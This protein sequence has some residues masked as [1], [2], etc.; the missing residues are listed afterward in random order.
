MLKEACPKTTSMSV[1]SKLQGKFFYSSNSRPAHPD[2][3]KFLTVLI[4]LFP[5]CPQEV[6]VEAKLRLRD[7]SKNPASYKRLLTDFLVQ[8]RCM[9]LMGESCIPSEA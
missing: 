7:V 5:P 3:S 2:F 9:E 6:L 4:A 8:V 1:R